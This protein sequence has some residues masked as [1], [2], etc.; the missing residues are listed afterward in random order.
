MTQRSVVEP[1]CRLISVLCKL[2]QSE[3]PPR[4]ASHQH[5]PGLVSGTSGSVLWQLGGER[6]G[7]PA[8]VGRGYGEEQEVQLSPFPVVP[9]GLGW[10]GS[11]CMSICVIR[12]R[13]RFSHL[14]LLKFHRFSLASTG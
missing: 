7:I 6:G 2:L 1:R 9:P 11:Q 4:P 13:T 3:Q 5:R 10:G 14:F 12:G 8:A